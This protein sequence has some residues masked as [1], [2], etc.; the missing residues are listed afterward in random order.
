[1]TSIETV[2][3]SPDQQAA[4]AKILTWYYLQPDKLHFR[5]GGVAGTGKTTIVSHL[6]Q[7]FTDA[8]VNIAFCAYTGKAAQVLRTK[9]ADAGVDTFREVYDPESGETVE[10]SNVTTIHGLIYIPF[11]E[12]TERDKE[13]RP[14][15]TK[16]RWIKREKLPDDLDLIIV[17]EASMIDSYIWNDLARYGKRILAVG[18]HFQLPPIK[19]SFSLMRDLDVK[20]EHIHRQAEHSPIKVVATTIRETFRLPYGQ[21]DPWVA[22]LRT[23]EVSLVEFA[24]GPDTFVLCQ[25]NRTRVSINKGIRRARG[26]DPNRPEVGDRVVCRKN[27]WDAGI[28]NGATGTVTAARP[29]AGGKT[30]SLSVRLDHGI[31]Y[32]GTAIA[33][34]FDWDDQYKREPKDPPGDIW[35]YG[36]ALTVHCA[37]GS[38]AHR[39]IVIEEDQPKW[40]SESHARWL[41]TAVTRA[42]DQLLVIA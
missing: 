4:C 37:Q 23:S 36:Y 40:R 18:D 27:N 21:W 24:S 17:D 33:K 20:L 13:G 5:M 39:V 3:L 25:Y 35:D 29:A 34:F 41:Y 1:M 15:R 2:Q 11:E 19:S 28:F 42:T 31:D 6:A 14:E 30:F 26:F 9:L 7:Q 8:G 12:I 32:S 16:T 38:Q 10:I 22:K